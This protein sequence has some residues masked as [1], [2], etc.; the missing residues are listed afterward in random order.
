MNWIKLESEQGLQ[1][2]LKNSA[3]KPAFIFKHST[4]CSISQTALNRVERDWKPELANEVSPYYLDLLSFRPISNLI[5]E[6]LGVQHE[7]PQV[8]VIKNGKCVYSA[9]HFDIRLAE[10]INHLA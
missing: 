1:D 5:A 3:V 6:S 10:I 7:S 9:T 8:L 4:R 2:I